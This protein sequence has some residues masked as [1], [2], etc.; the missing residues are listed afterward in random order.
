MYDWLP[1]G[2][3]VEGTREEEGPSTAETEG[4]G[5]LVQSAGENELTA[6]LSDSG[7]D[8]NEL[9][10]FGSESLQGASC[11]VL[12]ALGCVWNGLSSMSW[13]E[14]GPSCI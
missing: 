12:E 13:R 6:N 7:L 8:F 3:M 2:G 10:F 4:V 1:L 9:S 11:V 14:R 5:V